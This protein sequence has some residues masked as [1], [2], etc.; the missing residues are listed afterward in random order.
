MGEMFFLSSGVKRIQMGVSF[1]SNTVTLLSGFM[2]NIFIYVLSS[3]EEA[4]PG[5]PT[6]SGLHTEL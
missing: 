4:A 2:I 1:G 3:V 5:H 6:R